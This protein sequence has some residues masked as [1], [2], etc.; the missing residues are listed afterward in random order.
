[1]AINQ[2]Q[3][4]PGL[5]MR[6]FMTCYGTQAQ[7]EGALVSTR[8]TESFIYPS[9][10]RR[11]AKTSE[12]HGRAYWQY[13]RCRRPATATSSTVFGSTKLPLT[14]KFLAM[15]L[16][17]QAKKDVLAL[18]LRRRLGMSYK[19]VWRIKQELMAEHE[20][21]R[22]LSG[23]VEIDE[24]Y[25]SGERSSSKCGRGSADK[26]SFVLAVS[27]TDNR[28]PYHV[29]VRTMP[30]PSAVVA[31]WAKTSLAVDTVAFSDRL[32]AFRS[33]RAGIAEH[34][35]HVAGSGTAAVGNREFKPVNV[36]PENLKNAIR[37]TYDA[38]RF[39]KYSHLYLADF[40]YRFN[41]RYDLMRILGQLIRHA[42]WSKCWTEARLRAA[43]FRG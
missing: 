24:A 34:I 8:W 16:M 21:G 42:G 41:H 40:Q 5:S 26:V 35:V 10:R 14:A 32:L 1:M 17:T 3:M 36:R 37:G 30:F 7:C 15:H 18:E 31:D 27:T 22:R 38:F 43:K 20:S 39:A 11:R 23:C 9:C 33:L 19:A 13:Q 12:R 28:K 6:E 2:A 29:V 4:Q 25:L